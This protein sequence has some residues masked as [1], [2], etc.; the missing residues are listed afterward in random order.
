MKKARILVV[1]DEPV[2]LEAIGRLLQS[3]GYDVLTADDPRQA[4]EIIRK[5]RFHILLSD[6]GMREMLGS[7][8]V[9]EAARIS[10]KTV[11][12]LMTGSSAKFRQMPMPNGVPLLQKPISK[13]KLLAVLEEALKTANTRGTIGVA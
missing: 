6:V 3:E 8:L 1:D 7:E 11:C 12:V 4:L 13:L 10:P 2:Y 5:E 9:V